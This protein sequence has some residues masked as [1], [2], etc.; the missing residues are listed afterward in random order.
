MREIG[1]DAGFMELPFGWG[2]QTK[3]Q[4]KVSNVSSGTLASA[5][6]QTKRGGGRKCTADNFESC[7]GRKVLL[8]RSRVR[9]T[10]RTTALASWGRDP[11]CG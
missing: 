4:H 3:E 11:G 2:S 1:R 5:Q 10:E 8:R 6:P 7:S 9:D